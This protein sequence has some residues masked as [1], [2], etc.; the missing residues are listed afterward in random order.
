VTEFVSAEDLLTL[1]RYATGAQPLVRDH[2][3]LEAAAARPQASVFGN[4]AY[5]DVWA[6]A[7]ALGHSLVQSHPLVDGNKR[8]GW[9]AMRALLMLNEIETPRGDVDNAERFVLAVASGEIDAVDEIVKELRT[10]LG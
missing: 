7:A 2:G 10:L 9:V 8:L 6:K 5:P 1:A 4:D 3:L